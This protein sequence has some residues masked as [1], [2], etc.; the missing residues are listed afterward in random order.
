MKAE[1]KPVEA[2]CDSQKSEK[3]FKKFQCMGA[4]LLW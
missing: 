1:A 2:A 4:E 3:K